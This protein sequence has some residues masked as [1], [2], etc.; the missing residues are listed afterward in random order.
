[1]KGGRGK[2]IPD[3]D[4]VIRHVP[5]ARLRRDEDD[6]V[7]GF[8]PQA[9]QL[10]PEERYLSVN[11]MEYHDGD[12]DTQ[13]ALSIWGMRASFERPLGAKSAFGIAGV[14]AVKDMS[15][16]AG[17]RVRV[18]HEPDGDRNPGHAGIRQL[19]RDDMNLLEALAA[20][21]FIERVN[22]ADI[23]DEPTTG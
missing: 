4:H 1:M 7:I 17:T 19:P 3:E 22:N 6:N 23:P 11:W 21:A 13:I 14:A 20:D 5:W 2:N 15:Q 8:L 16:A 18:T 9:F 10:R 12:R